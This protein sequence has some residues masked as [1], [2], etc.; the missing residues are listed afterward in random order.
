ML[1]VDDAGANGELHRNSRLLLT[2][3]IVLPIAEIGKLRCE[4]AK[5]FLR[6]PRIL[7]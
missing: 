1:G 7:Q 3:P 6:A 5:A 4:P 2:I